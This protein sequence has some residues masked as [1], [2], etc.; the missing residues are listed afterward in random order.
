[1]FFLRKSTLERLPVVMSAVRMGERALQIGVDDPALVGAIAAKVGLSGNAAVVVSEEPYAVKARAGVAR[2]GALAEVQIAPLDVL[3][4]AD[5]AF[6]VVV[7]HA[8]GVRP[9]LDGDRGVAV[10]RETLRVLRS[11]GRVVVIEGS[12]SGFIT[13]FRTS[14]DADTGATLKAL[15]AAGF[16]ATRLLAEREGYAFLEGLKP[17]I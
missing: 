7:V 15:S 13:R 6:D 4:F 12:G 16:K 8:A 5:D 10:L 2:A 14:T 9:A 11:G 17:S 1:M 3:P